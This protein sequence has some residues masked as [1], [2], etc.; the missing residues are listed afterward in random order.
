[1]LLNLPEQDRDAQELLLFFA[2]LCGAKSYPH[3]AF[4]SAAGR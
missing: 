1:M 3:G 2:G 4:P